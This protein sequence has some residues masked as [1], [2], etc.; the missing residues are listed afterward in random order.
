[1]GKR[2][3]KDAIRW[4]EETFGRILSTFTIS[5]YLGPKF[6]YLDVQ[7]LSNYELSLKRVSNAKYN[8][9]ERALA[10]WQLRYDCHPDSG[11]TTSELLILKAKEFWDKL[12]C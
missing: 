7:E 1:L 8:E 3:H 2:E 11:S 9:L 6:A 10:E 5:D 12:P 4:F